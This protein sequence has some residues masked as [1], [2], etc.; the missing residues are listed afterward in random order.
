MVW[1]YLNKHIANSKESKFNAG[2]GVLDDIRGCVQAKNV[3][4]VLTVWSHRRVKQSNCVCEPTWPILFNPSKLNLMKEGS[5]KQIVDL[6][7]EIYWIR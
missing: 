1:A 4:Q 3:F 2:N 7:I 6:F 5:A